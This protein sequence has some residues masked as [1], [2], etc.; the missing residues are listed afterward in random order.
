MVDPLEQYR[1]KQRTLSRSVLDRLLDDAPDMDS[2]PLVSLADQ[3]KEMREVIRRDLE[4]LLNTRRNPAGPPGTLKELNDALV[5]YGMDGVLSANLVTDA[6]KEKLAKSIE[7]RI[8]MF[9]TRL[10]DVRV[11]ILKNR[12]EGERA[13]RMRIQATFRLHEG[14]PPISFESKIDPSTQRFHVEAANG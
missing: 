1:P 13:L 2:D 11:T 7:R 9:E 8:S 3:V 6:S 14:M 12:M 4:A 5:S 10:A